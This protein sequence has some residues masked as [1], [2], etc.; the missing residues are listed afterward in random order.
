LYINVL[1]IVTF[2]TNLVI[3]GTL[4]AGIFRPEF[5]ALFLVLLVIKSFPDYLII[6]ATAKRYGKEELLKY[7]VPTQ[8]LY[9]FYII[10]VFITSVLWKPEW[11]KEKFRN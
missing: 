3:S 9:P 5:F 2:V 11:K 8:L 6:S 4:V 7:F 10:L 1:S